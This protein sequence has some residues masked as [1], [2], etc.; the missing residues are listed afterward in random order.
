MSYEID[1]RYHGQAFE[2]PM[3]VTLDG[4]AS[5]GLARLADDFDEEHRRL[6]T[7]NMDAEH[8]FVNLRAVAMGRVQDIPAQ[9]IDVGDGNPAA[10][11]IRDHQVW[12][13]G[14][15]KPAAIYDRARLRAGDHI[16]GPAIV[17]EM[18]STTLV[19]PNCVAVVDPFGVILINPV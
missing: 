1:V 16:A 6:F 5:G 18:D 10:A 12:V 4:F 17:V 9:P 19:L 2:V 3:A 13:D 8:E 14:G 15:F 7:F 11:K